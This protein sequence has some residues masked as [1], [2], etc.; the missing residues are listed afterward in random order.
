MCLEECKTEELAFF[1][2]HPGEVNMLDKHG[3]ERIQGRENI[4]SKD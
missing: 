3:V 4:G 2:Y 1:Y